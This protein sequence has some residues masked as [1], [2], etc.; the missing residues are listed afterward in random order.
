MKR[1]FIVLPL[2]MAFFQPA[3][4]EIV[5]G[6]AC[7]VGNSVITINEF[8]KAF[9]RDK[10]QALNMGF[11][12]PTKRNV[13]E[14][15]VDEII[16]RSEAEKRKIV[17]TEE[18]LDGIIKDLKT[19]NR[20]NDEQFIAELAREGITPDELKERYRNEILKTRLINQLAD[21]K[22]TTVT[23]EEMQSFYEDPRN[24]TLFTRQAIVKLSQIFIPV[25]A[26]AAYKQM[27][28][29]KNKVQKV[30]ERAKSGE[31]FAGLVREFSM[32][33]DK[34]KNLG[35]LGSFTREQLGATMRPEDVDSIFSME[36]GGV[37]PPIRF[38]E[39]YYIFR[40]D[41]L[42]PEET[43]S[44]EDA[45]EYIR[46][47]VLRRKGDDQFVAWLSARKKSTN[48]QYMVGLE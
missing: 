34:D 46:S 40:A 47:Y 15:L 24:R 39:G 12:E 14:R 10:N 13:M 16:L 1:L 48:I 18:E 42:I 44:Y 36:S 31:S 4:A 5:N 41:E 27:L 30:Y 38:G 3:A 8:N 6:V 17:V 28:E 32:S 37:A 9:Q 20:L 7:K 22:R 33:P 29:T 43:L 45:R 35:V 21:E 19:Q 2:L 26:D 11:P 25:S 23:E